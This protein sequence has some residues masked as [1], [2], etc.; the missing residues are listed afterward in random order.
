M[1]MIKLHNGKDHWSYDKIK[2]LTAEVHVKRLHAYVPDIAG[3]RIPS[4]ITM[5]APTRTNTNIR[6]FKNVF[7]SRVSFIFK[8]LSSSGVG[9]L[10]LKLDIYSSACWRFGSRLT[11]AYLQINEYSANVPPTVG[12]LIYDLE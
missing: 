5:E 2:K 1:L 7:F 4:P 10:S 11:F 9:S 12:P 8:A 6:F 3:V